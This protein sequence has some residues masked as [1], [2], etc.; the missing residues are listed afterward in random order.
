MTER[1]LV[2]ERWALSSDVARYAQLRM[3]VYPP[4]LEAE[5]ARIDAWHRTFNAS[6]AGSLPNAVKLANFAHG[7]IP[8]LRVYTDGSVEIVPT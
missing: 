6:L 4:A 1:E 2:H 7:P 3:R 8:R 5:Q